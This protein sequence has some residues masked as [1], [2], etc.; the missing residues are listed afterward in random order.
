[1]TFNLSLSADRVIA[2]FKP[3]G[4]LVAKL[5]SYRTTMAGTVEVKFGLLLFVGCVYFV[6]LQ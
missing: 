4:L 3:V 2:F 1:V 6:I 5:D